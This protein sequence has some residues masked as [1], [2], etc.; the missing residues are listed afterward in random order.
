MKGAALAF[1]YVLQHHIGETLGTIEDALR[2]QGIEPRV[3]TGFT[4]EPIPRRMG[5]A[6]GLVVLGGP[7]G[8]SD[9][10]RYPFLRDE[11]HLIADA[12]ARDT[13]ILGVC[14]GGQLLAHALGGTVTRADRPEIGWFPLHLSETAGADLLWMD[15]PS[16]CMAFHWHGD[17]FT[18]P[19]GAVM[20][21]SSD[22]TPCQA[23]RSGAS[24]Y[25]LQ[26]HLEV[27]TPLI[28]SWLIG[29]GD[30]LNEAGANACTIRAQTRQELPR[31]Q[32][33]AGTIFGAWAGLLRV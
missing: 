10:D 14:L 25:G 29:F 16:P 8:V 30:E 13:P 23:F 27:T 22:L 18:L 11:L 4:G 7:M 2:T 20:L 1:V 17:T 3:I 19:P 5:D 9:Q 21:A 28:E 31:L 26:C 12:L 33:S 24:A 32:H 6:V 15:T